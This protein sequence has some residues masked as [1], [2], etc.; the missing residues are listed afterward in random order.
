M[1]DRNI[2]YNEKFGFGTFKNEII[3]QLGEKT[4]QELTFDTT[5]PDIETECQCKCSNMVIF[6][7]RF[8]EITDKQTA[9]KVLSKVRHG[10]KPSQCAWAREKFL[11]I[12][13]LD[14]FINQSIQEGIVDFEY[15]CHEKKDF[16]G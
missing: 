14:D 16:Y 13:N 3:Q 15:L 7:E 2:E 1:G 10:L 6:M 5:I 12:G 4:Y 9:N 8:D 11:E